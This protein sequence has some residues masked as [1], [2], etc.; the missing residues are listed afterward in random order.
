MAVDIITTPTNGKAPLVAGDLTPGERRHLGMLE[1]RIQRGLNTFREVGEA[2]M[3]I[4]DERLYRETHATFDSYCRDRWQ[5]DRNRAYQLISA[6]E[7]ANALPP[8]YPPIANEAQAR[9]LV[10]LAHES[11]ELVA[12]VWRQVTSS[13]EPVSATRIRNAVRQHIKPAQAVPEVTPTARLV[14]AINRVTDQ[15]RTWLE[16]GPGGPDRRMVREAL[17]RLTEVAV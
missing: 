13:D 9:E 8:E 6:A 15:Y 10:P 17:A 7:V 11:P 5:F 12:E 4:R 14:Q 16:S 1:K 2:L 3:E